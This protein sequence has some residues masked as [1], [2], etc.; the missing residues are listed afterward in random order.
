MAFSLLEDPFVS[1]RLQSNELSREEA[2]KLL[3]TDGYD[4]IASP[5]SPVGIRIR[6]G[7][8]VDSPLFKEGVLTIQDESSQLV[9]FQG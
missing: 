9:I 2:V 6:G 5:V 4:V 8:I 1:V 7:K 3:K